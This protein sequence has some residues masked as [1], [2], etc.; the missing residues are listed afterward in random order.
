MGE[1][2]VLDKEHGDLKIT[3]DPSNKRDIET[4]KKTFEDLIGKGF[5]EKEV[6][7]NGP[8]KTIALN[9]A[10]YSGEVVLLNDEVI[11]LLISRA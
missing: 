9:Y 7:S 2:R 11:H 1:L 5:S 10:N 8:T 4:A 6:Y 3:W